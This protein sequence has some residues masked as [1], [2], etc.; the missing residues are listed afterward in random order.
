MTASGSSKTVRSANVL[1]ISKSGDRRRGAACAM[2]AARHNK[3]VA[4]LASPPT[5]STNS[6]QA[7]AKNARMD[8][9]SGHDARKDCYGG[10]SGREL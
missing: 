6:G 3:Q 9:F 10:P 7:L 1:L 5:P 2:Q 4:P 8:T